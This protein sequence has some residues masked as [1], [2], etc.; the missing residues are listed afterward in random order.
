MWNCH[1]VRLIR[2]PEV[3]GQNAQKN[4][5]LLYLNHQPNFAVFPHRDFLDLDTQLK[6]MLL[7]FEF[8][9]L[10]LRAYLSFPII[11]NTIIFIQLV[12]RQCRLNFY[13]SLH[14]WLFEHTLFR[15]DRENF[16]LEK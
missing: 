12:S 13:F 8:F 14:T 5:L 6:P 11:L 3:G 2:G 16:Q 1:F 15:K 10:L 7:T 9:L 4:F